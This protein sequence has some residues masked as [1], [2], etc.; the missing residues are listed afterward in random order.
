MP[1]GQWST[2][3]RRAQL[4]PDWA[5][6]CAQARELWGT[7]CYLCAHP[8]ATDTDHVTP[9][10]DHRVTNLRP[11]CGARCPHCRAEGRTPC[12]LAKSSR[13]GGQAA[14]AIRPRRARPPEPHPGIRR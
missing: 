4:P 11:A 12:H 7:A 1:R 3:P 9:G 8:G 5:T 10:A 2:S 13:E 14:Q 6:L